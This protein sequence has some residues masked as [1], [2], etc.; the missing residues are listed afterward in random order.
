M[1]LSVAPELQL[2]EGKRYKS[3]QQRDALCI[4]QDTHHL[5]Q[6]SSPLYNSMA[7]KIKSKEVFLVSDFIILLIRVTHTT[8]SYS[9]QKMVH[10]QG[11]SS[12]WHHHTAER[13]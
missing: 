7:E 2:Q 8:V 12:R 13:D 6:I 1:S 3:F 10:G 9:D 11:L 5:E 4:A